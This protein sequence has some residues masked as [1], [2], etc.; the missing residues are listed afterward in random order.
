MTA[1]LNHSRF[2]NT[3]F[4]KQQ[5]DRQTV[6]KIVYIVIFSYLI[7]YSIFNSLYL[8]TGPA[9]KLYQPGHYNIENVA[10]NS[11]GCSFF[12]SSY[13]ERT[14]RY[15]CYLLLVF[16]VVLRNHKWLAAGAATSVLTYSGVAAIHLVI[17]FATNNRINLQKPKSHCESLPIPGASIP[18]V[19]CAG[20]SDPDVSLSMTI[21][22][23]VMLGVLPIVAWSTTFRRSTSKAILIIWLLLLAV[24][25]TFYALT[26]STSFHFQICPQD[27]I[28]PLP[29]ANFQAPFLDQSWRDSFSSLVSTAQQSSQNPRN[30][31]SPACIHSC[32]ATAGYVGRKTQDI[33]VWAGV[34]LQH[35]VVKSSAS[36]RYDGVIFWWAYT[37]LAFLTLLTTEKRDDFP[38]GC[39]SYSFQSNIANSLWRR[40]GNGKPSRT[41]PSKGPKITFS[42]LAP[43][44]LLI[45]SISISRCWRWFNS[46]PNSLALGAF[47]G[48]IVV[49]E[50]QNAQIWSILSQDPFLAVG[51][52]GNIAVVLLVLIAAGVRRIWAGTGAGSTVVEENRRPEE[53]IQESEKGKA[54]S[55]G[56]NSLLDDDAK[57]DYWRDGEDE[58]VE[59]GKE[60]W[61]W[62]IGYSSWEY[63]WKDSGIIRPCWLGHKKTKWLN[64]EGPSW[65]YKLW[66]K[67]KFSLR[68]QFKGSITN[69]KIGDKVDHRLYNFSR[70][71]HLM[72][73]Q[74]GVRGCFAELRIIRHMR[75]SASSLVQNCTAGELFISWP[76]MVHIRLPR[77]ADPSSETYIRKT[78]YQLVYDRTSWRLALLSESHIRKVVHQLVQDQT[79]QNASLVHQLI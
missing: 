1:M 44:K 39:I 51:Q 3:L 5:T 55:R 21:V 67:E 38:N 68:D 32:F 8:E 78:R 52:W 59:T 29:T 77:Q 31:S 63:P 9:L 34:I 73:Y 60:D 49:Q 45:R 62:R 50:K 36:H 18:F 56:K 53:I 28:E 26:I 35:P 4:L 76:R 11:V 30:G 15:I 57:N 16:T 72:A 47:F 43:L 61:D 17:L 64:P 19:A 6:T 27:Y 65:D 79:D 48:S 37:L 20:V 70:P 69:L 42:L 24:G 33:T 2:C 74:T 66:R 54:W 25:H 23:S 13:Y 58:D 7:L 22:S 41:L 46:S 14:P 12:I 71:T 10:V 75:L 40:G